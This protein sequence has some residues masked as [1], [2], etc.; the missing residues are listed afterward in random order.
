MIAFFVSRISSKV[1]HKR[2]TR[3]TIMFKWTSNKTR[4]KDTE[5]PIL[6]K[7]ASYDDALEI[8]L[9]L[10]LTLSLFIFI[11]TKRSDETLIM[12]ISFLT[13]FIDI[14]NIFFIKAVVFNCSE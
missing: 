14:I 5:S 10:C 6:I 9:D 3:E 2:N 4:E 1:T 11:S 8:I 12:N 7:Y 13:H